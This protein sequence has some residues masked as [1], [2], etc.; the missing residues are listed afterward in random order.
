[1]PPV[2]ISFVIPTLNSAQTLEACL[3]SILAQRA[4]R[5]TYE[6]VI[7]DAG[8]SDDTRVIAR[9]LGVDTIV[10]NLLKTGE[11]GKAAGIKASSGELI[12]LVDSDNILPDAAWLE[13]MTAPFRDRDI[14]ACEPLEYTARRGD[15]AL[16]R[17]FALLGMN[18]PLCL[19]VGNYDRRCAVTGRWTGLA[20]HQQDLGG[21]LKLTLTEETLPTIGAN[22]F[23]FRR[24]LLSHVAWDP[25]FFD[26]DVM[27][28]AVRAGF[29]HVAKV[30]TGIVHLYCAS[31]SAFARKQRRRIR[32]FLFF[33]QEKQ[34]TYPWNR[35]K[36]AGIV[37][38]VLATALILPLVWQ[39][40]AGCRR[41]PDR[42]WLYHLPVCWI[43]L[44]I[45]GIGALRKT[46]GLPQAPV[47]RHGWQKGRSANA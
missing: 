25:Y 29:R 26:I 42:A 36:K 12:A 2:S 24:S 7:A 15:P 47:A 23:V 38:F 6:I 43:T 20:V 16:T 35:Q 1:M 34:R 9:R 28:Q 27:H 41:R 18:D 46:L 3:A 31:L 5:E 10:E 11:A 19:F 37:R 33:A 40:L 8:S 22:G 13:R 4:P 45:Y 14:V 17:Y 44:W 21:Y 39:A 30:K 32:D